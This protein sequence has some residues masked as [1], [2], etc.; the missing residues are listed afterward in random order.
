[1]IST[2]IG[3]ERRSRVS[4]YRI[5]KGFFNEKS[6]NL[7]QQI[8]II[9]VPNEANKA[10][11]D[12][13]E[14][15]EIISSTE[16]GKLYGFGSP[17][18]QAMRILRPVSG[19][20][21]G[22]IPTFVLPL[23][24]AGSPLKLKLDVAGGATESATHTLV[25]NGRENIDG[26]SYSFFI[27]KEDTSADVA[28]YIADTIN[29]NL[30]SPFNAVVTES[31]VEL[32]TKYNGMVANDC[33]IS[34]N[35]EKEVGITYAISE[36]SP[37]AGHSVVNKI[38][39]AI[40]ERWITCIINADING[41]RLQ[42]LEQINGVPYVDNPT[43][44][45]SPIVF[46]PFMAFSGV[47]SDKVEDYDQ[48]SL[49]P[50]ND[51]QVTNV[52]CPAPGSKGTPVEAAANVVRLFARTMQDT[53]ERDVNGMAYP[54]MP[55]SKS[56]GFEMFTDYNVRDRFI[57]KGIS[58]VTYENN[59]FIIQD[60]VTTYHPEGENP[61][62]FNYCRNLNLDWNIKDA[63]IVL[64]KQK[65]RDKVILRD[66][67]YTDSLHTIKPKEWKAILFTLFEDFGARALFN[68]VDFSKESLMVEVDANN[69]NR[70]NTFFRY[71]RTGVARIV[72][73]DVEAGF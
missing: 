57:K 23:E 40:S 33:N 41:G 24:P 49:K 66:N 6:D 42:E 39:H 32:T 9:G 56:L 48:L 71:K 7:P 63:Y 13:T 38:E 51:S 62:Q 58:N 21:V 14:M 68:D 35:A 12:F 45:Y 69:P 3:S 70:F 47:V 43:G 1:M 11:L 8:L 34:V 25:V 67:Q 19:D 17:I 28:E 5:K 29:G 65:L 31:S 15:K 36:V 10:L 37:G 16:A 26:Y 54:D 46:K 4:G 18:H 27:D 73:T 52:F 22:G 60:L 44:R 59:Q 61:L 64:E 55:I 20:G 53:P 30:Y 50:T 2:A 72:S